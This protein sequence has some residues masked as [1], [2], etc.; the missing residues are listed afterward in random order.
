MYSEVSR[1]VIVIPSAYT[2]SHIPSLLPSLLLPSLLL[3][4]TSAAFPFKLRNGFI[5]DTCCVAFFNWTRKDWISS[6]RISE[7]APSFWP[8]S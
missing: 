1:R 5:L 8:A 2:P 6:E 3:S 7:G 4:L